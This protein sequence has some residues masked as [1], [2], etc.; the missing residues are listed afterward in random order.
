MSF[1]AKKFRS[2]MGRLRAIPR[3]FHSRRKTNEKDG[4]TESGEHRESPG[5][6][7]G[8]SYSSTP[9]HGEASA[10]GHQA[11]K[12]PASGPTPVDAAL[13][14]LIAGVFAATGNGLNA[15]QAEELRR[16]IAGLIPGASA[17]PATELQRS[18]EPPG[19]TPVPP[20]AA[21]QLNGGNAGSGAVIAT[22]PSMP[23]AELMTRARELQRELPN[24]NP[25]LSQADVAE[26]LSL[27]RR[28]GQL[29]FEQGRD[30]V[31][32]QQLQAEI[33]SLKR[34]IESKGK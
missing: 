13:D 15:Q 34:L 25:G 8:S 27:V 17:N 14:T 6:A 23:G 22:A 19:S 3:L 24:Q 9:R 31:T 20:G 33:A 11:S 29:F 10:P 26:L 30:K 2:A 32:H 28:L 12:L 16:T 7:G 1:K 4:G 18:Q 21:P 5:A